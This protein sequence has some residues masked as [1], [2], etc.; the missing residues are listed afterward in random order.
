MLDGNLD[1]GDIDMHGKK[2]C[3]LRI[4]IGS[5]D[6]SACSYTGAKCDPGHQCRMRRFQ[7]NHTNP[8]DDT[9]QDAA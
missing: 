1:P 6:R 8:A 2:D 7:A 9:V 5:A 4:D 3:F